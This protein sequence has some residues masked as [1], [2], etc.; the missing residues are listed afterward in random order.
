MEYDYWERKHRLKPKLAVNHGSFE[1]SVLPVVAAGQAEFVKSDHCLFDDRKAGL[2]FVPAPGHT[3]GN[4]MIHLS[5]GQDR[6]V[7]SGDV[8]HHP[9]QCAAPWL[10]NAADFDPAAA[11]ATRVALLQQLADTSIILLSGHFPSPTAGRV[12]S[13]SHAFRFRFDD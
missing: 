5:G 3:A 12:V 9:I 6:A 2:R 10:A 11:L 13:H 7:M 4:M 1:D 8:I